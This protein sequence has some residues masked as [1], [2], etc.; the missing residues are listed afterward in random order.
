MWKNRNGCNRQFEPMV[1]SQIQ[2]ELE[3]AHFVSVSTDAS[4]R[5]AIKMFPV[6]FRYYLPKEGPNGEKVTTNTNNEAINFHQIPAPHS[7]WNPIYGLYPNY[8]ERKY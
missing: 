4:N 2:Q 7:F 3:R 1:F 5:K 8:G 6:L